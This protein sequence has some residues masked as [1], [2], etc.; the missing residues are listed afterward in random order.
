M[1]EFR[2][3]V[4]SLLLYNRKILL[5][6]DSDE[7][8]WASPGGG[9]DFGED[10][11][12]AIRREIKEETGLV[13]IRIEKLLFALT[14][15][16]EDHIVGLVYLCYANSDNVTLSHEHTDFIWATKK[17]INLLNKDIVNLYEEHSVFL[18]ELEI[19]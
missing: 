4:G 8:Y 6:K 16:G 14:S 13:D 11:H 7:G 18:D 10:L 2:V 5:L 1:K 9:V 17:E 12:T 3:A 15:V 19:D